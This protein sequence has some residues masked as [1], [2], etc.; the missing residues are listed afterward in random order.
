MYFSLDS[1]GCVIECNQT[2]LATLNRQRTEVIGRPY[3]G[4]LHESSRETF[5]AGFADF[6]RRGSVEIERPGS[7]RTVRSSTS[8]SSARWFAARRTR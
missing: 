8:G 6:L 3:E 7:S 1:E 5:R 4:L 2:M